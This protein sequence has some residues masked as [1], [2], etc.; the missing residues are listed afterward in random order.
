MKA[1]SLLGAVIAVTMA[2]ASPHS[3]LA[4]DEWPLEPGNYV[5]MSMIKVDDGHGLDYANYLAA[6]WRKTQD[7]AKSQGWITDYQIWVNEYPREGEANIYLVTWFP[8]FADSAEEKKRDDAYKAF[9][10]K[11]E[12]EMQAESG[13]RAEY[14]HL[15]G[16]MLFRS[17]KWKQ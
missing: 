1:V 9:M 17:M 15:S 12:A 10:Q 13:K 5:D 14:R 4:A 7:F 2:F 11:S 3:A 16:G 6:G 8:K